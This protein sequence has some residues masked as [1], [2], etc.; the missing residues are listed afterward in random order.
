MSDEYQ[1]A[2]FKKGFQ[3]LGTCKSLRVLTPDD[4]DVPVIRQDETEALSRPIV[5]GKNRDGVCYECGECGRVLARYISG[6][7][8]MPKFPAALKCGACY[9]RNEWPPAIYN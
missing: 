2:L 7:D 5:E 3:T 8:D 4:Q 9:A 1:R 6:P